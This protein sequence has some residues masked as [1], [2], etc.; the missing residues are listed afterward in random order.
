MTQRVRIPGG[1][2]PYIARAVSEETGVSV[3]EMKGPRR[4]RTISRARWACFVLA[5]ELTDMSLPEIGLWFGGLDHT[6]VLHGLKNWPKKATL[7]QVSALD[8]AREKVEAALEASQGTPPAVFVSR[9]ASDE[10]QARLEKARQYRIGQI[11]RDLRSAA[12]LDEI[13]T[14]LEQA[15]KGQAA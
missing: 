11:F 6:S 15:K 4:F 5:R 14:L 7:E 8:R 13:E 2:L 1:T 9:R 3:S 12:T 10:W